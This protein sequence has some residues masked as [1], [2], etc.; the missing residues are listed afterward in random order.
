MD[1]SGRTALLWA[2]LSGHVDAA[3][4]LVEFG[5]DVSTSTSSGCTALHAACE[6]GKPDFVAFLLRQVPADKKLNLFQARDS[7]G[8]LASDLAKEV[9]F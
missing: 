4:T 6:A 9:R 5:A 8:K 2:A 7:D 1:K 3:F